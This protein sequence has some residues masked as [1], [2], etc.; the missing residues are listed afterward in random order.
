MGIH[1]NY[2]N[3]KTNSSFFIVTNYQIRV[4]REMKDF[5]V[6]LDQFSWNLR[7]VSDD[8]ISH[9]WSISTFSSLEIFL[10]L[11]V[12]AHFALYQFFTYWIVLNIFQYILEQNFSK[13]D[14]RDFELNQF[15]THN[16]LCQ[17]NKI[18]LKI[19]ELY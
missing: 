19:F 18:F 9:Y 15:F 4:Y 8:S 6:V 16:V 11:G 5:N 12:L 3:K 14:K 10:S 1:R 17:N 7:F 13:S 2:V